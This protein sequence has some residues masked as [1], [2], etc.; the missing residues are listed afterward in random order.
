MKIMLLDGNSLINRAFY[1]VRLLS[2]KDGLF[3]NAIYGFLSTYFKLIADEQPDKIIVCFDVSAKTFRH[4]EFE[5]YK[6]GRSAM[7]DEL[8]MQFPILKELLSFM[9]VDI[10]ELEGYEAD[11]IIGTFSSICEQD[12]NDCIIVTGDKDALQLITDKVTVKL[13]TSKA[14]QTIYINYTPDYFKEVYGFEPIKMIDLK[15]LM[16]DKSDNIPGVAGIGEKT[17]TNLLLDFGSLSGIYENIESDKIKKGAREKLISGKEMAHKSYWLATIDKNVPISFPST[18]LSINK[19][20]LYNL[21]M[22]LQFKNFITKFDLEKEEIPLP[23]LN[24][25]IIDID[26]RLQDVINLSTNNEYIILLN[27]I[28][29][30]ALSILIGSNIYIILKEN[31]TADAFNDFTDKL[32]NGNIKIISFDMRNILINKQDALGF[33]FDITLCAYLLDPSANNYNLDTLSLGY[34]SLKSADES[35]NNTLLISD[36]HI[37]AL[38]QNTVIVSEL[39]NILSVKIKNEK[40]ESLL[41]DIEMKLTPVLTD[42]QKTG[43][44]VNKESLVAFSAELETRINEL[45][46]DIYNLVGEEFN[47]NSP[48]ILADILFEKLGLTGFKKTKTGYSTNIEVLEFLKDK[49]PIIAPIIEYRTLTKLKS[50]YADGLTKVIH[51]DGRIHSHFNQTITATGRLSSTD[52]NLQNIPIRKDI[53]SLIRSMFIADTD[54]VLVIADYSQIELRIL[55]DIAGDSEMISAFKNNEDIHTLTA[56]KVFGVDIQDVTQNMRASAK[57]VNFGI[58]YGISEFSLAQ[59]IGV[60]VAQAKE[61]IKNYLDKY[62]GIKSYMENIKTF[63]LEHGYVE[64]IFGR[65]RYIPEINSKNFNIRSGAQRIA[66]NTPIQGS[67]ADIIK[68]A[69]INIY[70]KLKEL[71]A[72]I[73][74]QVHDELIIECAENIA[75]NVSQILSAEMQNAYIG[76]VPLTADSNISKVWSK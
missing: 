65:R 48:K 58:V 56:A 70:E 31:H 26:D 30:N 28:N 24:T 74:L 62:S 14:G 2:T 47:I 34:L 61:Y 40:M 12:G 18:D 54:K 50:T 33:V 20:E 52:P 5:Q 57:A 23:K 37:D 45:T 46:R 11:D 53:G 19:K 4:N 6:A 64:T 51:S 73:I 8:R 72:K 69:M 43:F 39:Y 38:S 13:V 9:G 41:T 16:G 67:S 76:K 55:A 75:D 25:I 68:I 3:T 7:P 27:D 60:S 66:L 71:D 22:K 29:F 21:L 36:E 32:F 15:A 59:D 49:H 63:A 35:Y 17:A 10:C 1:G 42:M 44:L